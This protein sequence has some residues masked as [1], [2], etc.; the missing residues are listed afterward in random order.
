MWNIFEVLSFV[1]FVFTFLS[2]LRFWDTCE[3]CRTALQDAENEAVPGEGADFVDLKPLRDDQRDFQK[4]FATVIFLSL[5]KVFKYVAVSTRLS[6]LW[7]VLATAMWDVIAFAAVIFI[8]L[9]AFAYFGVVLFGS[10]VQEFHNV[11]SALAALVRWS[12]GDYP[13][14]DISRMKSAASVMSTVYFALFA[15]LVGL[16]SINLFVAIFVDWWEVRKELKKDEDDNWKH[17]RMEGLQILDVSRTFTRCFRRFTPEYG[18][19]LYRDAEGL[20]LFDIIP[21]VQGL[22]RQCMQYKEDHKENQTDGSRPPRLYVCFKREWQCIEA[23]STA[24]T[25]ENGYCSMWLNGYSD[26][27]FSPPVDPP[28]GRIDWNGAEDDSAHDPLSH[29]EDLYLTLLDK[30]FDHNALAT[31]LL[32]HLGR[33][34]NGNG[35]HLVVGATDTSFASTM[36]LRKRRHGGKFVHTMVVNELSHDGRGHRPYRDRHYEVRDTFVEFELLVSDISDIKPLHQSSIFFRASQIGLDPLKDSKPNQRTVQGNHGHEHIGHLDSG[37]AGQLKLDA[38]QA[39]DNSASFKDRCCLACCPTST[40]AHSKVAIQFQVSAT[41]MIWT[42]VGLFALVDLPRLACA[43]LWRKAIRL[44]RCCCPRTQSNCL[45]SDEHMSR[46]IKTFLYARTKELHAR[47]AKYDTRSQRLEFEANCLE[48]LP[49]R[50]FYHA[51][52]LHFGTHG[53]GDLL[54]QVCCMYHNASSGCKL[55]QSDL[56]TA[57]TG[58]EILLQGHSRPRERPRRDQPA[59]SSPVPCGS[60]CAARR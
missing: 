4:N 8:I 36:R 7:M 59:S 25:N 23:M 14:V 12:L 5:F 56:T 6:R 26:K 3:L 41:C 2:C 39:N 10:F 17:L 55:R 33:C 50:E 27:M 20:E 29:K 13:Y 9:M 45:S 49:A 1:T 11:P 58:C 54:A 44:L 31:D 52:A 24:K 35:A 22:R 32:T 57:G 47:H 37:D 42:Q 19:Q 53:H 18:L 48:L 60:R 15:F 46:S 34:R 38:L 43:S 28:P 51:L 40:A 30:K 21:K 16:T